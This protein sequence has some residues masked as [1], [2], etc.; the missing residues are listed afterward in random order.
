MQTRAANGGPKNSWSWLH[1]KAKL[2]DRVFL[3]MVMSVVVISCATPLSAPPSG[4]D[5]TN[6]N[7]IIGPGDTLEIF[8]WRNPEVSTTLPVRPDGKI[9]APLVED[10]LASG[11]TPTELAR[12]IESQLAAYIKE[13][14]VTVM[15]RGF[16]GPYSQQIRVVGA[17]AEPRELPYRANMTL[18]DLMIAVGGL[19]DIAAGNRAS[20]IRVTDGR[21]QQYGVRLD[22]LVRYGDI[23]ANVKVQPGD[24]LIIPEAWF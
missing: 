20:L 18:L 12:N 5:T 10:M 8:V 17:A 2:M 21:Q 22:D 4:P 16:I 14:L 13:P 3:M 9:S 15:V 7:Y 6:P 23:S 24:I 19:T 1:R 11:K